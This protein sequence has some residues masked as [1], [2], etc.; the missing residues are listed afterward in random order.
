ME[1]TLPKRARF[2]SF[3]LDLK[4]GELRSGSTAVLLQEQPLQVLRILVENEGALVSREEIRKILWPNDTIVEFEHSINAAINKLRK[5][6][7]DP[8]AEPQYIQTVARRGY[9]LMVP[10]EWETPAVNESSSGEVSSRDDG[11]AV[12]D[13]AGTGSADRQNGL[14]LPRAGHHWRGRHGCG[15]PCR[16]SEA[17]PPRRSEVPAGR[18]GQRFA[19][20]ATIRARSAHCFVAEPPQHLRNLRIRRA[21]RAAIPRNGIVRRRD[22]A[23]PLVRR[24]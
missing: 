14:A 23:R 1:E 7:G 8:V 2:G 13:T 6:L 21:R 20:V 15:V 19:G 16:G 9:R 18:A 24:G 22:L 11:A 4:A 12:R 17:G 5:A 3:S 10:V